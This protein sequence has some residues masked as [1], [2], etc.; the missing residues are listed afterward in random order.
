MLTLYPQMTATAPPHILL[1]G[2]NTPLHYYQ[3]IAHH[4]QNAVPLPTVTFVT[5]SAAVSGFHQHQPGLGELH[6]ET[7]DYA[8]GLSW[9]NYHFHSKLKQYL[10]QYGVTHIHTI[11]NRGLRLGK[12]IRG[13][14]PLFADC[15]GL[16]FSFGKKPVRIDKAL[17]NTQG[18][19]FDLRSRPA[20]PTQPSIP[21][22]WF[23]CPVFAPSAFNQRN[24]QAYNVLMPTYEQEGSIGEE[25]YFLFRYLNESL[26]SDVHF[27]VCH[28]GSEASLQ[29]VLNDARISPAQVSILPFA[30]YTNGHCFAAADL[31]VSGTGLPEGVGSAVPMALA[32]G[33]PLFVPASVEAEARVVKEKH[34]GFSFSGSKQHEIREAC[35]KIAQAMSVRAFDPIN[36]EKTKRA[37]DKECALI[38]RSWVGLSTIPNPFDSISA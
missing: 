21:R 20:L 37:L 3:A 19:L 18:V 28:S 25:A 38:Y 31:I 13:R 32:A 2:V 29:Q 7:D 30:S 26:H 4:Y 15:L 23:Y 27:I 35:F 16:D 36:I 24:E 14:L 22:R 34:I 12:K 8:P 11:G 10:R 6:L 1:L 5:W 33:K 17:Q 9:S